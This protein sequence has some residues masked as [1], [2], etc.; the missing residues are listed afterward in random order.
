[1]KPGPCDTHGR[2]PPGARRYL[3][4]SVTSGAPLAAGGAGPDDAIRPPRQAGPVARGPHPP[5]SVS[6]QRAARPRSAEPP[7]KRP[8][9]ASSWTTEMT[10]APRSDTSSRTRRSSVATRTGWE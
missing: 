6:G 7:G 9:T 10:L 4:R 8:R 3:R 1:M 5:A 2:D